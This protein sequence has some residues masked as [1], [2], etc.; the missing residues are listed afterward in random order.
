MWPLVIVRRGFPPQRRQTQHDW[1]RLWWCKKINDAGVRFALPPYLFKSQFFPP[2][3]SW[4]LYYK[5]TRTLTAWQWNDYIQ[6]D[7]SKKVN[8]LYDQFNSRISQSINRPINRTINQSINQ[9][10]VITRS[11]LLCKIKNQ[12]INLLIFLKK[13]NQSMTTKRIGSGQKNEQSTM[14]R[15]QK[16]RKSE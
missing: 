7:T 2:R 8:I 1:P 9:K 10:D 4:Q 11:L 3:K 6:K 5:T 14:Y 13:L 15:K 16:I 12:G